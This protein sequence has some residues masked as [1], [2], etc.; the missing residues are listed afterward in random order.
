MDNW[1][2]ARARARVRKGTGI[3]GERNLDKDAW[4]GSEKHGCGGKPGDIDG[5]TLWS[6]EFGRTQSF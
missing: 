3:L 1:V 6:S 4:E 2:R 5:A